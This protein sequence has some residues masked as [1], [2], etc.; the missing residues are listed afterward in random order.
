MKRKREGQNHAFPTLGRKKLAADGGGRNLKRE[1]CGKK[2]GKGIKEC[3]GHILAYKR[4]QKG[5]GPRN[6]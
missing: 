6:Q 1:K 5:K 4:R 2:C 3:R